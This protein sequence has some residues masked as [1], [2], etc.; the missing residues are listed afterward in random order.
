MLLHSVFI[1]IKNLPI[2]GKMNFKKTRYV[3]Y[4]IPHKWNIQVAKYTIKY[5]L[6]L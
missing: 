1:L 3:L 2:E 4:D 6:E 5:Q